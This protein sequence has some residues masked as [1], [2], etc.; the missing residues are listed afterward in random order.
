MSYESWQA[1]ANTPWWVY[2]LMVGLLMIGY[3][4]NKPR[5]IRAKPEL[6]LQG[7]FIVFFLFTLFHIVT[8]TLTLVLIAIGMLLIGIILGWLQFR[9][10]GIQAIA[11][12]NI[13]YVPGSYRTFF[14]ILA[15]IICKYIF[16]GHAY[17][18]N[19]N[20]LSHSEYH[21]YLFIFAGLVTGLFIG[22]AHYILRCLKQGP[23]FDNS[24]K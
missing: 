7:L 22:R 24:A 1:I 8:T 13:I 17:F 23:F 18:L 2:Y 21:P 14:L 5:Y 6:L 19:L 12:K 20:T 9:F 11:G 3:L 16:L 4:G 15:L 10:Q